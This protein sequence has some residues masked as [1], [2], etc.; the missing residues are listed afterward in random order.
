MSPPTSQSHT[1]DIDMDQTLERAAFNNRTNRYDDE[2]LPKY[3]SQKRQAPEDH[4]PPRKRAKLVSTNEPINELAESKESDDDDDVVSLSD[5]SPRCWSIFA[6]RNKAMTF[7]PSASSRLPHG[8]SHT[9][10]CA[11]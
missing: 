11:Y 7:A 10:S 4:K 1:I 3:P 6:L 5:V 8:V 2:E 9:C